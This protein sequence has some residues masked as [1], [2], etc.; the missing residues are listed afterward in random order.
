MKADVTALAVH[1]SRDKALKQTIR[2]ATG[3]NGM[4]NTASLS[5]EGDATPKTPKK[6]TF[7]PNIDARLTLPRQN[8]MDGSPSPVEQPL[9][10]VRQS[11]RQA[12]PREMLTHERKGTP[13]GF[14]QSDIAEHLQFTRAVAQ[15]CDENLLH[16][17]AVH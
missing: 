5:S 13:K 10:G 11:V 8:L 16:T 2:R 6:L 4:L 3:H 9:M 17:T 14:E 7:N 15:M 1:L 12:K